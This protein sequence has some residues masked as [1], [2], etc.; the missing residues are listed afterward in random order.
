MLQNATNSKGLGDFR[1]AFW[2]P[3]RLIFGPS[4]AGFTTGPDTARF[5]IS[6]RNIEQPR[7]GGSCGYLQKK[8][9][10]AKNQWGF[11]V[12]GVL[13]TISTDQ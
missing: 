11:R 13:V 3:F 10:S 5:W 9:K 8:P 7:G 12:E 6:A 1:E 2:F 4:F